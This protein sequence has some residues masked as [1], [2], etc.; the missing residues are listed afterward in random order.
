MRSVSIVILLAALVGLG[1]FGTANYARTRYHQFMARS[2]RQANEY[3]ETV[4]ALKQQVVESGQRVASLEAAISKLNDQNQSLPQERI[5]KWSP[6]LK[7]TSVLVP[8]DRDTF[9]PFTP[10]SMT[11][12]GDGQFLIALYSNVYLFDENK[13]SATPVKFNGSLPVW[14]PTAIFYSAF[15][16]QVFI[17]NYGGTDLIITK[18]NRSGGEVSLDLV[19]RITDP[20]K[21]PEGVAVSRGGR[22]MAVA[23]HVGAEVFVFE[24]DDGAWQLRWSKPM[25]AAHGVA[26]IDDRLYVGGTSVAK[27]NIVTGEELA[28]TK[29][30]G[31]DPILFATCLNEDG[32]TGDLIGTDPMTGRVFFLSSDLQAKGSFGANGP[33]FANFSMPYCAYREGKA[34]YILSTYQDRII[35]IDGNATTSF[36]LDGPKWQYT[37]AVTNDASMWHGFVKFDSPS[38]RM[39]GTKVSPNYGSLYTAEGTTLLMP[40][41]GN[42][43]DNQWPY[44][45]TT[46]AQKDNWIVVVANSSPVALIYDLKSGGLGVASLEDWDCWAM[47]DKVLCPSGER[48]VSDLVAQ[49]AMIPEE[50]VPAHAAKFLSE[51]KGTMVPIVDY[52]RA[53]KAVTD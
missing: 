19:E 26:I 13:R 15:Y 42:V 14:N 2:E 31:D 17:A 29:S 10:V 3:R 7:G 23:D 35:K 32:E 20:L 11:K 47:S 9:G 25:T 51:S 49:K 1:A 50:P 44:Y 24:R 4:A 30:L 52:W 33:T 12:I 38:F 46:V 45:L 27:Y 5:S 39:F 40:D 16:D 6:D 21:G 36:E 34:I 37:S 28:R 41:R 8:A 43:D 22:F 18:I 48:S 53:W